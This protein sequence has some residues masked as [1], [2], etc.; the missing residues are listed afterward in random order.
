[1]AKYA[2]RPYQY[3]HGYCPFA[4]KWGVVLVDPL[5]PNLRTEGNSRTGF[6]DVNRYSFR[7][8]IDL[9]RVFLRYVNILTSIFGDSVSTVMPGVV[10][11]KFEESNSRS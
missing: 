10:L 4:H 3:S 8:S 7:N 11:T 1:M 6:L 9:R 2:V 5:S